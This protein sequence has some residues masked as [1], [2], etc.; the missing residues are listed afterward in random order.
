M[1]Y[2]NTARVLGLAHDLKIDGIADI[3][4]QLCALQ[5]SVAEKVADKLGVQHMSTDVF[6][7]GVESSFG[8]I[9][10]GQPCPSELIEHDPG[11][12]WAL[13]EPVEVSAPFVVL[14]R[15]S[16]E[17]ASTEPHAY[18][19]HSPREIMATRNCKRLY[20]KV[21]IQVLGTYLTASINEALAAHRENRLPNPNAQPDAKPGVPADNEVYSIPFS[22]ADQTPGKAPVKGKANIFPIGF[23]FQFDGYTDNCSEDNLGE[24][25]L[26]TR[27][28]GTLFVTVFAS[29]NQEEPTHRISLEDARNENRDILQR[30]QG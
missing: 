30:Q 23:S 3:E 20:Q 14:F 21:G 26:I 18:F 11:S 8:P 17:S 27:E 13:G 1:H 2:V 29:V 24:T 6:E 22:I 28:N 19:C 12:D 16:K 25:L 9:K 7:E 4:A 15:K 10:E 5:N